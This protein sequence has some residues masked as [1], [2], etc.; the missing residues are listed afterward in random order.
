[1]NPQPPARFASSSRTLS[2]DRLAIGFLFSP[3]RT[4]CHSFPASTLYF[5]Q[6]THSLRKY[7]GWGYRRMSIPNK[8]SRD[9]SSLPF[10]PRAVSRGLLPLSLQRFPAPH[11]FFSIA[12]SLFWQTPRGATYINPRERRV[13]ARDTRARLGSP[14]EYAVG[15]PRVTSHQSQV[16]WFKGRKE[17]R[18]TLRGVARRSEGLG[19]W[20]GVRC[21]NTA[22]RNSTNFFAGG[23]LEA[24][25]IQ[26]AQL[27]LVRHFDRSHSHST[28]L[29]GAGRVPN[30]LLATH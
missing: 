9:I 5:Q 21:G 12:C 11:S 17:R 14:T 1:M 29:K 25:E 20:F 27:E 30:A 24:C 16:T 7:R 22:G 6:L 3:L 13:G 10:I 8:V 15:S 2:P 23:F 4:L 18:A 26:R 19:W 28:Y